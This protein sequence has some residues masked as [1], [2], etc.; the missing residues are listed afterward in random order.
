ME[1][2]IHSNLIACCVLCSTVLVT[3]MHLTVSL[4]INISGG[5]L[6]LNTVSG[7]GMTMNG[8]GNSF[9][10]RSAWSTQTHKLIYVIFR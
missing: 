2:N 5:F 7:R 6:L 1:V 10:G 8:V 9:L 4:M 3:H